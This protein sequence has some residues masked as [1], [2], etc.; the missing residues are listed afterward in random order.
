MEHVFLSINNTHPII[1]AFNKVAQYLL[2][3]LVRLEFFGAD[4]SYASEI[5]KDNRVWN[6]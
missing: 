3:P 1:T 6:T 4:T 5:I 2:L